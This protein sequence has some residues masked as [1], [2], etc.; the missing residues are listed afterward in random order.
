MEGEDILLEV[1]S[2]KNIDRETRFRAI[3]NVLTKMES[4]F[5]PLREHIRLIEKVIMGSRPNLT[6]IL[7]HGIRVKKV[8]KKLEFTKK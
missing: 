2:L 6:L 4:K 3:A 7:P 8:Y 1:E 5:I